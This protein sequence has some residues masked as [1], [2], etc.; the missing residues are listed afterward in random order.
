LLLLLLLWHGLSTLSSCL[1]T[2]SPPSNQRLFLAY[3]CCYGVLIIVSQL[4]QGEDTNGFQGRF[5]SGC[6]NAGKVVKFE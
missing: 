4:Y 1:D 3:C 5:T 2:G 6:R